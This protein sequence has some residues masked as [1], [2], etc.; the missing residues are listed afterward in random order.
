MIAAIA[1]SIANEL[2]GIDQGVQD[3]QGAEQAMRMAMQA[4]DGCHLPLPLQ[5]LASLQQT[6]ARL[7]GLGL[8]D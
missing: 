1:Q 5:S 2:Q 8:F 6:L 4:S 7:N 3:L